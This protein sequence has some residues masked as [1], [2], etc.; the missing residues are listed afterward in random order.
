M[1]RS[2][3]FEF[4]FFFLGFF[5]FLIAELETLCDEATFSNFRFFFPLFFLF[6]C[7]T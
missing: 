2:H 3:V 6:Q 5:F 7:L 1:R 4:G